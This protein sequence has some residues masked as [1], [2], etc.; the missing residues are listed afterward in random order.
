MGILTALGVLPYTVP[1]SPADR[2]PTRAHIIQDVCVPES[3]AE[4]IPSVCKKGHRMSSPQKNGEV[5]NSYAAQSSSIP[6]I[7]LHYG[8]EPLQFG[9]LYVPDGPGPHPVVLLI[10]GGF[11]R[12]RYGL[13]LMTGLAK[14]L[15]ERGIAAWNIEYRRIGDDGGGWPGTL[16]DVALAADYLRT[17]GSTYA[18]DPQRVVAVG[19]SAGGHLAL[20]LAAR[21]GIAPDSPVRVGNTP[22]ALMGVISLAGANDLKHVWQLHLSGDVVI[23]FLGGTPNDVPERYAAASPAAFLPLRVPQVLIHGTDD[24]NVP[25]V[26]SRVYARKAKEAGDPVTLIELPNAEH[27]VVIDPHSW[28]WKIIVGEI[29]KLLGLP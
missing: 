9:E 15:A 28:A 2:S 14:D 3:R 7:Q 22:L 4:K 13:S 11:W 20:W 23:E 17:I 5:A 10:H 18:I 6:A 12:A 8:P 25:L 19:H 29:Q 27:F 26:V 24:L 16:Q 1:T 21:P